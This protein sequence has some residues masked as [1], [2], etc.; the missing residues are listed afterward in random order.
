ML[1]WVEAGRFETF[2]SENGV[3]AVVDYAHTPDALDNVLST[4]QEIKHD[5]RIICVVGAGGDRDRTKRPE[6]AAIAV[7][8]SDVVYLT[9]D[10]PRSEDPEAIIADMLEGV[11]PEKRSMVRTVVD[12]KLAMTE[13]VKN[14][15]KGDVILVAGKGHE[16]YQEI[17]GVK[18]HFDDREIIK[19]LLKEY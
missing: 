18:H 6:M 11:E 19:E 1:E 2:V 4:L 17:K 7:Q 13:A 10:N 9:S 8:K 16:D 12:R 14:A 3:V 5:G 15:I